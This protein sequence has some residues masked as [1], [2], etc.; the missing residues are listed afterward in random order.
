MFIFFMA[1]LKSLKLMML[2]FSYFNQDVDRL[3]E[4]SM[5]GIYQR[6]TVDALRTQE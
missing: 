3:I 4:M 2:L 1:V 5:E 6:S